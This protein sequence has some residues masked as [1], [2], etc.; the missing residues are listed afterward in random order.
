MRQKINN[1][2]AHTTAYKMDMSTI[3]IHIVN[4]NDQFVEVAG[5]VI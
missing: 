2:S 1:K 5:A 4:I 3:P